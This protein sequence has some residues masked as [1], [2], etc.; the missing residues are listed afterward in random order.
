EG[1][2]GHMDSWADAPWIVENSSGRFGDGRLV[3]R[4]DHAGQF[5]RSRG[6]F[7]VPRSAQGHPVVIQAGASGRGRRFA[8]RW[9]EVIF[10]TAPDL[11]M[12]KRSYDSLKADVARAGRDPAQMK[13]CTLVTPVC[14]ETRAQAED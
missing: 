7:T 12:G 10:S 9:G 8:A 2:P 6:P 4:L 13:I 3:H 14:G 1:V 5:F 11:A